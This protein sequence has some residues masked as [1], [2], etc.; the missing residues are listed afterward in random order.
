MNLVTILCVPV[1]RD[2]GQ[3]CCFV[4]CLWLL[5]HALHFSEPWLEII[6]WTCSKAIFIYSVKQCYSCIRSDRPNDG[7]PVSHCCFLFCFFF[8][9]C[10]CFVLFWFFFVCL[11]FFF[12]FVHVGFLEDRARLLQCVPKSYLE[13]LGEACKKSL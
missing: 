5:V 2:I 12:T 8:C 13:T 7:W 10:F 4:V 3:C 6:F 1:F 9:F 11:F